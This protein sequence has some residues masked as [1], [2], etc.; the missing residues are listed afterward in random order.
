MR[1]KEVFLLCAAVAMC[2]W[3]LLGCAH[4][5][6]ACECKGSPVIALSNQPVLVPGLTLCFC[7]DQSM[8]WRVAP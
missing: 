5:P 3:A 4:A 7:E 2:A 8:K 1:R 6:V